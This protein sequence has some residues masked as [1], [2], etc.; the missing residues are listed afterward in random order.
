[1]KHDVEGL[2][3]KKK[4]REKKKRK[5]EVEGKNCSSSDSRLNRVPEPARRKEIG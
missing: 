4:K 2:K 3:L 1:M 5:T